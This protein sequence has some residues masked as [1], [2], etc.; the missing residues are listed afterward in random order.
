[1]RE[2]IVFEDEKNMT[3]WYTQPNLYQYYNH[4]TYKQSTTGYVP[5]TNVLIK[6]QCTLKHP[7]LYIKIREIYSA[8]WDDCIKLIYETW[9]QQCCSH[10]YKVITIRYIPV[11]NVLIKQRCSFEHAILCSKI[12]AEKSSL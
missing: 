12:T 4:S 9:R 1:M 11:A 2:N 3:N 8:S 10:T 5:I 7:K 6:W